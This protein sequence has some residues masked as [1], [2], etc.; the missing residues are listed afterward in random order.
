MNIDLFRYM[1][2]LFDQFWFVQ[3]LNKETQK[4]GIKFP[5]KEAQF[6]KSVNFL[7]LYIYLD[8]G[9]VITY[10]GF[11]KPTDAKR[12][13]NHSNFHPNSVFKAIPFS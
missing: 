6:G 5:I 1:S 9:N 11:L 7:D 3:Q 8:G 12:Y 2:I 10:K 13:L 4:Y